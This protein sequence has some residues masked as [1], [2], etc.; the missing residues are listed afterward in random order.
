MQKI[1]FRNIQDIK[2]SDFPG[3]LNDSF[4]KENTEFSSFQEM[5][6]TYKK[7]MS[8]KMP[9]KVFA[10]MDDVER[11]MFV[12]VNTDFPTWID[13]II[14]AMGFINEQKDI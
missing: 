9:R 6:D 7:M 5:E 13:M 10:S 1:K 2:Y 4:M 12:S 14:E 3:L 11:D 8:K